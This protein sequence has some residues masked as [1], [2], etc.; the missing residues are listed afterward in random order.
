[1]GS[2]KEGKGI[3]RRRRPNGWEIMRFK[4]G[5]KSIGLHFSMV[6]KKLKLR[7]AK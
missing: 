3:R 5:K 7:C 1:M 6:D 4:L 2:G